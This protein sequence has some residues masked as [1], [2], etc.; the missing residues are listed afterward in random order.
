MVDQ[1]VSGA[2][3]A[4]LVHAGACEH[5]CQSAHRSEL[6]RCPEGR[7]LWQDMRIQAENQRTGWKAGW[8]QLN[9]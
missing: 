6:H 1:E 3:N 8:L 4:Y 2:A 9:E 5:G 7:E